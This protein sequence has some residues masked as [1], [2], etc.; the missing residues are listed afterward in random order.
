MK[1]ES[2][3]FKIENLNEL[4]ANYVLFEIIGLNDTDDDFDNNIQYLI[5][6]LSYCLKHPV[7]V[8]HKLEKPF[9]VVK[10]QKDIL[11]KMPVEH[12][13]MRNETV[14][15]KKVV[16]PLRLD[17]VNYDAESKIIILR[18]L[19]FDIQTE[20]NKNSYLW[21]PGSGDAFFSDTAQENSGGV[22]IYN[23]FFIRAVELPEGGFGVAV[24]VT[25][26]YIST[27]PLK[28][29][30]SRAEFKSQ[31]ISKSH[32]MYQ[33]GSKRYEIKAEEFS[34][35]N[36]SQYKFSR[37]PSGQL[38]SLLQD[39]QEHFGKSMPPNVA[40][41]PDNASVLIYRT[42]DNQERRVIAGL[43]FRVF[44]TEDPIVKKLHKKSI[45]NPF[46]R[47]RLIKTVHHNFLRNLKYG[48]IKLLINSN[49]INLEKKKFLSP[50]ILF[51]NN[52]SLSVRR[53]PGAT[54]TIMSELG[55]KRKA[56]LLDAKAGF[57][58]NAAFE[59]QYF[60]VPQ[61]IFNMYGN[62]KYFL[63]DL[64]FH[65]DKMHPT[66]TGWRP[67]IIT[68]DNRNKKNAVDI[69]FEI[70]QKIKEN[71]G[72]RNG[73]YALIMLPSGIERIKRQHDDLAALVVSECLSEH[74]ITA[75]IM[76]SDILEECYYHK[77]QNGQAVYGIKNDLK[78]KFS[79]YVKGVAINQ[80]LL[81]NERWPY[82]L[83]T[84]LHADLTIGIDVKRQIA[85]FTFIDKFSKNILTKFDK[86]TNKE[87]LSASQMI[88][89]LVPL[90]TVQ[91]NNADY[92]IKNIV[93]HRD[94]RLFKQEKQGI[95][96]AISMLKDKGVLPQDTCVNITEIPKYSII[97]FRLFQIMEEYQVLSEKV[98]KGHVLNPEIGSWT[99][100][101]N[102]D[103]FICTTGREF[104][105][106]GSSK[107]LYV[108]FE[109]GSMSFE[110]ILED[111]YFLSCLAF[112]KPDDCSRYPLTIK[113]TDRR[114]NTLGSNFDFESLDILKSENLIL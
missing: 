84:P 1:Y 36:A 98:D 90:I 7:T 97:P 93:I 17:F 2:N 40:N 74:K 21:Q 101:G 9:L 60:V 27:I 35:L 83:N 23:G 105:H 38:V 53:T 88:K 31:H 52:V 30:I 113:I 104:S 25:K 61:T 45:L 70:T 65:V 54:Q 16:E 62:E 20:L 111:I 87:K 10:D 76:H 92:P 22:S 59:P 110:H 11:D 57:Y 8:V 96:Q 114:I 63:N 108:K 67:E 68:Y 29:N 34:D 106:S 14:Y 13:V 5:K 24:D 80:V 26:K 15:F 99:S 42:N 56:L 81:N 12:F 79:G 32:L 33:Y 71:I 49:P 6:S 64:I 103:A 4:T 85:G 43:C 109:S 89:M 82:V 75:S 73:G 19:Q 95:M 91:K 55:R 51:G 77:L 69:G 41:L 50:D 102:K 112:T 107:P 37:D 58:T 100:F 47:R 28:I 78:G 44:D 48:N 94:G 86:S 46:L 72:R 39:T 66:E 18:F 3:I